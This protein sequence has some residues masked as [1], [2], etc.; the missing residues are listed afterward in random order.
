MRSVRYD[1]STFRR[2]AITSA[3]RSLIAVIALPYAIS[4]GATKLS[5]QSIVQLAR[6]RHSSPDTTLAD[7]TSRQNTLVSLSFITDRLAPP[8][9]IVASELAS[10]VAW[11]RDAGL[12]VKMLGQRYV[13]SFGR[14]VEAGLDFGRPW[15]VATAP[16]DSL[17]LLGGID[18]PNRAAVHPF[19]NGAERYY[20]YEIGDTVTLYVADRQVDLVEVAVTP[21]RGDEALVVGSLWVD[22]ATGDV[23]AMQIRFVGMP[24]WDADDESEAKWANRILSVTAS[25]QQGLW[26]QRYWL[27]YRQE[28]ELMVRIPF[29][30]NFAVP[31][32]FRNEF[33]RYEINTGQPIAW[34]SPDSLRTGADSSSTFDQGATLWIGEGRRAERAEVPDSA[35]GPETYPEREKTQIRA[36]PAYGGW[37][38]IRPPSDTL[39]AYDEWNRPLEQ[40]ASELTLPSAEELERRAQELSPDIVGRKMF[41]IQYDRLPEMIR[42]NR[43]EALGVGLSA[44]YDIPR[45][46]FWSLGGGIGFGVADLGFKGKLDVRYDAPGKRF[47]LAGYSELHLGG[48]TLTDEKRANGSA[49]LR[50][51]FLGRDDADYYRSSGGALTFGKRWGRMSGRLGAGWEYHTSVETNTQIA[52]PGIWQDSVFPVNPAIDEGGFWRGDVAAKFYLG[53]WTRPTNRAELTLGLEGGTDADSLEY[54]QPRAALEG[55]IDLGDVVAL[56]FNTRGGWSAGNAPF[57]RLRG[58]GGLATVRGF[59]YGSQRGD[60]YW[61]GRLELSPRRKAITPVLFGDVGWAGSTE[62]WPGS[63]P[64]WSFGLGAS[65][66]WGILRTDLVFP[67]ADDVWFELYFA[68]SL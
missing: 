11:Q 52:I 48:T 7:Y 50:A 10:A 27:P 12:Q 2:K 59:T 4:L 1:H 55:R 62:D 53:D 51:F 35:R 29:I 41:M 45:R 8:K 14:D 25:M 13:T 57:Q 54:V 3:T 68:G 39:V 37:E 6:Q 17:R 60:S 22:A 18:I 15:F 9:L 47:D 46:P 38:I 16:G 42:Y 49:A 28:V 44:R 21:T 31:V 20:T 33:D 63:E 58:I 34:L 24:L 32:I 66:L 30:G 43:V 23:G 67:K 65:F 61:T 56:A 19:A 36:G 40:P 26:E 64:L 5:A